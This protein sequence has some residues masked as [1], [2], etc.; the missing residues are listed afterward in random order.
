MTINFHYSVCS[1]D[2]RAVERQRNRL[3][4]RPIK[5]PLGRVTFW[6]GNGPFT[7]V[8]DPPINHPYRGGL[9]ASN[10]PKSAVIS[11]APT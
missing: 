10:Y 8:S 6:L 11:R 5:M 4:G 3:G 2:R 9:L 1:C 7:R